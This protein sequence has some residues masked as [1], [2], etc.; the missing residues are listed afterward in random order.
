MDAAKQPQLDKPQQAVATATAQPISQ[1]PYENTPEFQQ[2]KTQKLREAQEYLKSAWAMDF[3]VEKLVLRRDDLG[4]PDNIRRAAAHK[5]ILA[6][7]RYRSA[8]GE[9][10]GSYNT[11]RS[12]D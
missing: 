2:W 5:Q 6:N 11:W 12:L 3:P 7:Q 9:I 8:D 4:F 10:L 1:F